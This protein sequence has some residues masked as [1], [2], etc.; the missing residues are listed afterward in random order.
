MLRL[1]VCVNMFC[2][3]EC[4][5]VHACLFALCAACVQ[6]I[7]HLSFYTESII[8]LLALVNKTHSCIFDRSLTTVELSRAGSLFSFGSLHLPL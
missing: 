2:V 1:C 6:I 4:V 5:R 3:V 8:G 7:Y